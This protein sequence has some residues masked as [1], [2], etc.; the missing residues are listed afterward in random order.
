MGN[1]MSKKLIDL[2][3]LNEGL[4]LKAYDCTSKKRTIGIGRN[5]QDVP[6]SMQE[7][8]ELFGTTSIS[9]NTANQILSNRGITKEQA[10][11]LLNNDITKCIKQLERQPFWKS[12]V[13]DENRKNAIIDL[14]FNMGIN[15][16]LEF[17]KTLA[18]ITNKDW[19]TAADN[20]IDSK[21]YT[22]V[23]DR[24]DRIVKLICPDYYETKPIEVKVEV[25]GKSP[26]KPKKEIKPN[27]VPK[28]AK[29]KTT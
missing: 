9:F 14:C 23:G 2:L 26:T 5:F 13:D 17:K 27:I 3:V 8:I 11:M 1:I 21:W 10:Y 29:K 7:C 15:R 19:K 16:L 18:A 12:V 25:D 6:F 28:T 24:G 20:L 4:K 22:Q